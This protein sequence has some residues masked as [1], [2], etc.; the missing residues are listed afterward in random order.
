MT[1]SQQIAN[2]ICGTSYSDLPDDVIDRARQCLLDSIGVALYGASFEASRISVEMVR[3]VAGKAESTVLGTELKAPSFL[4]ALANGISGH[5]T[6]YDDVMIDSQGHPSCVLMPTTLALAEKWGSSGRDLLGAFVLGSEVAGKLGL[7]MGMEHYAVGFHSTG[8]I[9]AV[10]AAAAASKILGLPPA[11]VSNAL[12]IAA[13]GA[14]GLRQNFGTMT[15]SWHAGHAASTGVMAALLAQKGYDASGQALDGEAGFRRA[16]QG[17][18]TPFSVAQMGNPYSLTKIQ[19]KRHPSCAFT[20][21]P[22][23]AALK[24]RE[25]HRIQPEQVASVVCHVMPRSRSVLIY[26]R[27]ELALQAKFSLEYCVAAAL[28]WG[29]LGIEQFTDEVVAL[30]QAKQMIEKVSV[31]LEPSLEELALKKRLINP[32]LIE[33]KLKD[34]QEFSLTVEE[35]RGGPSDPLS[36]AELEEKFLSCSRR[37]LSTS[38]AREFIAHV[39][40]L[41]KME[42]ATDLVALLKPENNTN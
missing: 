24:L 32:C 17:G 1:V 4:A 42:S 30:P 38:R 3:D 28:L 40:Q 35:A 9:G 18:E 20:H 21:P 10:A 37:T 27:P 19:F 8:T 29:H 36:W 26:Q 11:K 22:V 13:S 7:V 2:F 5:V 33:L 41:E 25:E 14:G 39:K 6:D 16:F 31:A 34:G 15:K 12:G 23:D